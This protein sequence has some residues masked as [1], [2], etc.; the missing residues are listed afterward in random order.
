MVSTDSGSGWEVFSLDYH[1]DMPVSI[2]LSPESMAMYRIV[3]NFLWRVQHLH[4]SLSSVWRRHTTNR[5]HR[6][7]VARERLKAKKHTQKGKENDGKQKKKKKRRKKRR[8][9]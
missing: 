2:V 3:F 9:K 7:L 8:S 4:H 5:Q 6:S 1:V